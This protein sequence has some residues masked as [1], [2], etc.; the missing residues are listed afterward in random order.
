MPINQPEE[1]GRSDRNP[2]SITSPARGKSR[3]GRVNGQARH[4]LA[5]RLG[6]ALAFILATAGLILLVLAA[7]VVLAAFLGAMTYCAIFLWTEIVQMLR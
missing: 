3:K 5:Y 4:S 7:L 6:Q 2:F 1:G